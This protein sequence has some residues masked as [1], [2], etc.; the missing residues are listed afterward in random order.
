M[1]KTCNKSQNK[2]R[3]TMYKEFAPRLPSRHSRKIKLA[4]QNGMPEFQVHLCLKT[5]G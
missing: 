4:L 1:E 5:L 2:E 3:F